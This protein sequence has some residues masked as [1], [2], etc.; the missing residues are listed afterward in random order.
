MARRSGQ[1][2]RLAWETAGFAFLGNP[3]PAHD[4]L[5][6]D[7]AEQQRSAAPDRAFGERSI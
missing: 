4:A 3:P 5:V 1:L 2:F 7:V 6:G